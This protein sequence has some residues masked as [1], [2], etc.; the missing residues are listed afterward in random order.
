MKSTDLRTA[1]HGCLR[2][3]T[4]QCDCGREQWPH[5]WST[6]CVSHE[7]ELGDRGPMTVAFAHLPALVGLL[8]ACET[9][10]SWQ[11]FRVNGAIGSRER[12]AYQAVLDAIGAVHK[13]EP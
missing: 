4:G 9:A 6:D 12:A 7:A 8:E 2:P 13:V 10:A 1:L 3:A 11:S 5:E